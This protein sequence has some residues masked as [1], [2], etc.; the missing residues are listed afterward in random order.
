VG[1]HTVRVAPN[2]QLALQAAQAAVP[3]VVLL[4]I[5]L[6]GWTDTYGIPRKVWL[7]LNM[8]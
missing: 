1:G 3:D 7:Y 8:S 6:P 2:G 5:G 4:D